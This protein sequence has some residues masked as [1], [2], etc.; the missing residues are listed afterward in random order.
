M[1]RQDLEFAV[2]KTNAR[3]SAILLQPPSA[4]ALIILGHGAGAGMKHPFMDSLASRL[5]REGL[6]TFRYQFPYMQA[7]RR[8]P[9][10]PLVLIA[11]VRAA[12]GVAASYSA[13]TP[14]LAGGK[15]MGGRMTSLAQAEEPLAGLQGLI[16]FGFPLHPSGKV[17]T[18][19]AEHL[20]AIQLPMLFLQGTRDRL[21]ASDEIAGV[22]ARLAARATLEFIDQAD[23]SFNV[24]K[25]SSRSVEE[26]LS[27]LAQ[28]TSTWVEKHFKKS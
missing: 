24:L 11:T 27:E 8:A 26:V 3:V 20:Y 5:A 16:F 1:H 6:G 10:R 18:Q 25:R 12:V 23:H 21:A 7:G 2:N 14:L 9:D 22:T 4:R 17:S 15:S 28:K 13:D 19:R